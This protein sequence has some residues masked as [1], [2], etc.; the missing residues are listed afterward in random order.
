MTINVLRPKALPILFA[1]AVMA[2]VLLTLVGAQPTWAAERSFVPAPNSPFPVGSTPT[3]VTNADFNSDG[4]VDLA[5]QN[6]GSNSVSV[7]L[8]NGD[9]TFKPKTD[10]AVGLVPSAVTSAD[11][12]SD[13]IADLAISNQNS[14]N[15]SV[16]LGQDLN[17]DSKGDG[18][19]QTKQDFPAGYRPTSVIS[20]DFNADHKADLAVS[21]DGTNNV[22]VLLGNGNGTFQSAQNFD[23]APPCISDPCLVLPVAAPNQVI[24]ADFNGDN[25]A[26]LATANVGRIDPFFGTFNN[27]GGVS[28]LLGKGDGTFQTPKEVMRVTSDSIYSI[29]AANLDA[30]SSVDLAA[31]KFNSNVASVL[32]GNGDGTF[33]SPQSFG[34]GL[35]PSAVTSA[36]LD[37]DTK[38]DD[39]A[40]SNFGSGNVSVL[41]N[42]DSGGFQ[43]ARNFPAGNGPAFV[44]G[45]NFNVDSYADLATANQNS[46]NVSVLLSTE[47]SPPAPETTIT[48]GPSG[49]VN[50]NSATF[51]FSSSEAGSTFQCALDDASSYSPCTSPQTYNNLSE[52]NHTFYVKATGAA[53][54]TTDL[55]P[56][57][58]TWTVDTIA[59]TVSGVSPAVQ[60]QNA[61]VN[62]NVEATFSEA[63]NSST[64]TSSTFTLKEQA[65]STSVAATVGYNTATKMAT[66]DPSS[67]LAPN[68]TYTATI[69]SGSS[70]VKDLAGN[71][72]QQDYS[73]TFT[74]TTA[75]PPETTITSG[76]SGT[77]NST[78]ATFEFS[79][80]VSNSSFKCKV[81]GGV[82]GDGIWSTC[83]VPWNI[84]PLP[85]GF[86]TFE[87]YAIDPAGTPDPTPASQ[88]W[89]VDTT[90]P[91]PPT[92]V[93]YTPALT[94]G[95]SRKTRPTATFSTDMDPSTLTASAIKLQVYNKTKKKWISVAHTVSYD[96]TSTRAKITPDAI[97]AASKKYRVTITTTV[98]SSTGIA[99]D[100][101][102]TTSGNQPKK[103]TFTTKSG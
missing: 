35:S 20:A 103:W 22:S 65:S 13:N 74:T 68:T 56:A 27:P 18:T 23:I 4:K 5:A 2:A 62:T 78:S 11:F 76:P 7:L 10:F 57:T 100:Q 48:S 66:L 34:V 12:N 82:F 54:N 44:V 64:L 40:I 73:W 32:K 101:D 19:F 6:A 31:T 26:D 51:Q 88:S 92:V 45:A 94:T 14:N 71:A 81:S 25:K 28:V 72:L 102:A 36:D 41:F 69:K 84:G 46:N 95:V 37:G 33:Q 24:S 29:T 3:T 38:A 30:G 67:N 58:R 87:V 77:V 52:G 79:S 39:L 61:T 21:N 85:D 15:V 42:N 99:L 91:A 97:L 8:S 59:P 89:T 80:S 60:N 1:A 9:G 70:G 98:K 53:G 55:T 43:A 50:S 16:L 63:M 83:Q 75:S 47:P 96:A 90:A 93:R 86:Y 17:G 49:T